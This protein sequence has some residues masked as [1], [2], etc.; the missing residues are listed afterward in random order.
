MALRRTVR[1]LGAFAVLAIA[2]AR[3]RAQG[4]PPMVTD[5][6]GTPGNH[7]WE[8]NVALALESRT[9]ERLYEAPLVDANYGLG[10][11]IQLKVELP[12]LVQDT[13][14]KT[15]SGLGNALFG[16]KYRFLDETA[17]GISLAVYPQ[18]EVGLLDSSLEKGLVEDGTGAILPLLAQKSFGPVSADM[19]LGPVVRTGQ[20]PRW[21]GGLVLGGDISARLN[22]AAEVFA[23]TSS[24]F[25]DTDAAFNAGGR[26]R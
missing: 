19:E 20:K 1:R 22:L 11:R 24:Q 2:S 16:V 25:S 23:E 12:W 6:T 7:N 26:W 5:D 13:A 21:F 4:G 3:A 17:S 9:G 14:A 8:I 10:E 15:L 18:V